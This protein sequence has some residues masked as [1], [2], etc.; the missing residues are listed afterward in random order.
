MSEKNEK[1]A[2]TP[3]RIKTILA[4]KV[5]E[6]RA[7][8]GSADASNDDKMDVAF[9]LQSYIDGLKDAAS[10]FGGNAEEVRTITLTESSVKATISQIEIDY[11]L[12]QILG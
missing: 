3:N 4:G 7:T 1:A 2:A 5:Q 11:E 12:G 6:F 9:A 8:I 10:A